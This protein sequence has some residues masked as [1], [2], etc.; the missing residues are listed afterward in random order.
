MR[1]VNLE[2]ALVHHLITSAAVCTLNTLTAE[3]VHHLDRPNLLKISIRD[4]TNETLSFRMKTPQRIALILVAFILI[5]YY[6]PTL[7]DWKP[8]GYR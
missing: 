1:D 4:L 2:H 7:L 8:K 3:F 6:S 5:L